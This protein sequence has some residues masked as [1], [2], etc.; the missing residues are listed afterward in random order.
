MKRKAKVN[1][2]TAIILVTVLVA[3]VILIYKG[4]IN[5]KIKNIDVSLSPAAQSRMQKD[6]MTKTE[7]IRL[8]GLINKNYLTNKSFYESAKS[9]I[10]GAGYYILEDVRMVGHKSLTLVIDAREPLAVVATGGK[11]VAVDEEKH[12]LNVSMEKTEGLILINGVSLRNPKNGQVANEATDYLDDALAV[13]SIIRRNNYGGVFTE[14]SMRENKEVFLKTAVSVP[15]IINLRYDVL[16]SLDIAKSMLDK[17][18][19]EGQIV[20]AGDYG[21]SIP[22]NQSETYIRGM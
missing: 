4:F 16:S 12:V 9:R 8:S 13:A 3:A 10:D 17:G 5:P 14:I 2:I 7:F 19:T 22:D 11:Y 18:I 6:G 20:V 1:P 15:V 21:Y